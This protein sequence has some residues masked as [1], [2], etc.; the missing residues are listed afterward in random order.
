M[1]RLGNPNG[2]AAMAGLGNAASVKA[3]VEKATSDALM[4][5][6]ALG[7]A[8][9]AGA[10]SAQGIARMFNRLG[11]RTP[12]GCAWTAK[13]VIRLTDRLEAQTLRTA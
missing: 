2:S 3:R 12:R 11:Y 13:A 8:Y 10:Q 5:R 9:A 6:R 7:D 4:M 1:K